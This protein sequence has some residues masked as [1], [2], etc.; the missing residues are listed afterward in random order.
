MEAA[1]TLGT[2]FS[3]VTEGERGHL[4]FSDCYLKLHWELMERT[5]NLKVH[6][7]SH[8]G[9]AVCVLWFSSASIHIAYVVVS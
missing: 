6:A 8:P 2:E 5:S 4:I 7:L 1:F 9:V 3:G